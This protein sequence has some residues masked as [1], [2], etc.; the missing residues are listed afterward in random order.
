[1]ASSSGCADGITNNLGGLFDAG[2][3][4]SGFD[5]KGILEQAVNA[6]V[7]NLSCWTGG[8]TLGRY[9]LL[10]RLPGLRWDLDQQIAVAG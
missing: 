9:L 8:L 10:W 5:I 6:A 1:M 3:D 7:H 4:I 2:I